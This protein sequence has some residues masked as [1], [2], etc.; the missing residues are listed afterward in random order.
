VRQ[1][2]EVA[3][4]DAEATV[5]SFCAPGHGIAAPRRGRVIANSPRIRRRDDRAAHL[6]ANAQPPR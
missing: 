4:Q 1:G 5:V 2:F 6:A 3:L